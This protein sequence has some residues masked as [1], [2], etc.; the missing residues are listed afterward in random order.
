[1]P[2]R[3]TVRERGGSD[4]QTYAPITK[5][6]KLNEGAFVLLTLGR[7]TVLSVLTSVRVSLQFPHFCHLLTAVFL[8]GFT[9][10]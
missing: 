7:R 2:Y 6:Q 10:C 8:P 3:L 5:M 1:M 9:I 4:C